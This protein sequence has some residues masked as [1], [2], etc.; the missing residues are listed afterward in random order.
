MKQVWHS[1]ETGVFTKCPAGAAL[2][3]LAALVVVVAG[4]SVV[5]HETASTK[6][7]IQSL[8]GF[9]GKRDVT[10]AVIA[11]QTEVMRGADVYV[12]VVAQAADDF[13]ARVRTT[14]ARDAALQ[15]KLMQAT[16][17]YINASGENPVINAVDMV[18]LASISR[19]VVKEYW[20]DQ[21][22][23]EA[24]RPLLEAHIRLETNVWRVVEDVLTPG[25]I[26]EV[27]DILR[28]YERKFPD[29][30]YV[31]A[32]RLPE[33]VQKLGKERT[34]PNARQSGSL[35]GLL[36]LNPLA[37]LDPTTQAIQQTRLL[38]QRIN[39]YLQRAPML[40][41][42]Q[43]EL[44]LYQ[45]AAQPETRGVLSNLNEVA[46]STKAFARTTEGLPQLI[47]DERQAAINQIFD[48]VAT[49]RTNL[50]AQLAGEE[51]KLRGLL[52]EARQ[53][54]EAGGQMA[55]SVNTA[56]KSLDAFVQYV[57]PP[58]TNP[59]PAV[60]D[61]NSRPFNVLDYGTAASQVGAMATNL[62]T[63]IQTV[64]HSEAQATRL[65]RQATAQAKEVVSHAFWL[66]VILMLLAGVILV[67]VVWFNRRLRSAERRSGNTRSG[68][69]SGA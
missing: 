30:R 44:T 17:A 65:T 7:V 46:Q 39:Y 36:Y 57:S 27:H 42:W 1:P 34:E 51:T 11:L 50:L 29:L 56:V 69:N 12:G 9:G 55:D 38:A 3:A 37:G 31:A 5:Q 41:S 67:F 66:G 48:R 49:E 13:S 4:C 45:L 43:A 40:W 20:V 8:A 62:T 54:L 23:G 53:T 6:S 28:E 68:P 22:F 59:A 14:E 16:A 2:A 63:L 19:R 60:P 32:A 18:I 10:N 61:T 26:E 24:A 64:N 58:D 35:F 21:R 33:L 47:D 15:W 25:Q 52:G